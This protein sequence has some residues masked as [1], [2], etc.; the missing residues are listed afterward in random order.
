MIAMHGDGAGKTDDR[1]SRLV[2]VAAI[3]RVGIH[4][5]DHGLV[6]RGPEHPH[7]QPVVESDLAAGQSR[8]HLLALCVLDPVE[9]FAPGL[10]A[11]C[12]GC[13]DAGAVELRGCQRQLVALARR[14]LLPGSVHIKAVAS[15]PSARE[16]AIDVDVDAEIGALGADLVGRDHVIHQRFD[17][18][19]LV[20]IE[21]FISGGLRGGGRWRRLLGLRGFGR[22]N[23][24]GSPCRSG[25]A[26]NGAFEEVTPVEFALFHDAS[27]PPEYYPAVMLLDASMLLLGQPGKRDSGGGDAPVVCAAPAKPAL[28]DIAKGRD[29]AQGKFGGSPC[30]R[31]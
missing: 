8:Q 22:R 25:A 21:E 5:L 15:A 13:L 23:G 24:G 30:P 18:G 6:Q 1:P 19:G 2:A 26:D 28:L 12:V 16:R 31:C 29:H 9:G 17:E 3:D 14:A 4:A 10:A 11:M 7:R 20:E 27:L